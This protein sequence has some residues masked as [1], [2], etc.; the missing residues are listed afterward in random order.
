MGIRINVEE[1]RHLLL[2]IFQR[3][4]TNT[5]G[6]IEGKIYIYPYITL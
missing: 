6:R 3:L 5:K 1:S 2:L 4:N